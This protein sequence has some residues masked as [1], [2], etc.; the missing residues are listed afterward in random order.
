MIKEP[1][2]SIP[3]AAFQTLLAKVATAGFGLLTSIVISR[4]LGPEG[5]GAY[6]LPVAVAGFGVALGHLGLEHA[7]IHLKSRGRATLQQMLFH[8]SILAFASGAIAAVGCV[9]GAWTTPTLFRDIPLAHVALAAAAIPFSIHLLYLNSLLILAHALPAAN[10]VLV[11]GG[12]VQFAAAA[13]MAA[14]NRLTVR[15]V[16]IIYAATVV[17]SWAIAAWACLRKI[18]IDRRF[19]RPFFLSLL[20]VGRRV[21][22]GMILGFLHLRV[23][24]FVLKRLTD[25]AKVGHYSLA[26]ILAET[27]W[28]VTDALAL[29]TLPHQTAAAP[30]EAGRL[31]LKATRVSLFLGLLLATGLALAALPIVIGLYGEPFRPAILPL[32]MLL[33]G[34]AAMTLQRPCKAYLLRLDRPGRIS[35]VLAG[36]VALNV[37]LN[38]ALIPVWE[39]AGAAA[40]STV[41]YLFGSALLMAWVLR[42]TGAGWREALVVRPEDFRPLASFLPWRRR[43][44]DKPLR[45]LHCITLFRP[46]VGGAERQAERLARAIRAKGIDM[47]IVTQSLPGCPSF[48]II[49]GIPVYRSIRTFGRGPLYGLTYLASLVLFLLRHRRHFDILQTTYLY[50]D[51]AAA[52]FVQPLVKRPLVA[53]PIT[54]GPDGDLAHF[55]REPMRSVLLAAF[56]RADAYVYLNEAVK[57]ELLSHGFVEERFVSIGNGVETDLFSPPNPAEKERIRKALGLPSEGMLLLFVGRLHPVKRLEILID[58]FG[59]LR[60]NH[61]DL[62]L[63][64][65]GDGPCRK[66]LEARVQARGIA[67]GV[68]FLGSS[69]RVNDVLKTGD[70]FALPSR[71]EGMSC[72]LLEAMATGLACVA[73]RIPGNAA[74]IQEGVNG[75]M[76]PPDD[77]EALAEAIDSLLRD[78]ARARELGLAARRTAVAY[79]INRIADCFLDLYRRLNEGKR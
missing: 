55:K 9:I 11:A 31:T 43:I 36:E 10:A 71:A 79:D 18:G 30:H 67:S 4:V 52:V 32:W 65:A 51:V 59:L 39:A 72:A 42:D 56:K 2:R 33:P 45:V 58:A 47:R 17:L 66:A 74:L 19:S 60:P 21:H 15:A 61:P 8:S 29:A 22:P 28:M 40:A 38:L 41:S 34:V 27:L 48:E 3:R 50:L 49:D 13:V 77:V 63:A 26:A 70:L 75:L 37:L 73:T 7:F 78:P 57:S 54:A 6:I 20:D 64:L 44:Q 1:A 12:A 53:C 69:S 46:V 35:A 16:L 76:V 68:T 24:L 14:S 5:R 62:H 23:D 25:L